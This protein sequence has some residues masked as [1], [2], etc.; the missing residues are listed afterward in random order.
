MEKLSP[1]LYEQIINSRLEKKLSKLDIHNEHVQKDSLKNFDSVALLSQ[2]LHSVLKKSLDFLQDSQTTSIQEQIACCNEIIALLATITQEECLTRCKI[3]DTGEILLAIGHLAAP[4]Q[5]SSISPRPITSLAQSCLFTG[6]S[7]EP[8]LIQEMKAEIESADRI[9]I[10]VS[11]IK[12]SG[13]RLLRDELS[14]FSQRGQLRVITTA[15]MGATDIP[16]VEF[17]AKLPNAEVRISYDTERTRLHAKAYYFKRNTGFSTAYIGSSN[18]S[19]PAIT[20]GLEWNVKLTE[21]DSHSLINKIEAS[22]ESYW[23]DPEFIRYEEQN[24]SIF[25]NAIQ[26]ERKG[27]HDEGTPVFF[28]IIPFYYQKEILDRLQAERT[29][30]HH[31]KNLIVAA[32]GTGKTVISAFDFRRFKD[33]VHSQARLLFIAHREEILKQSLYTFRT[34]LKDY[35]FGDLC[36]RG[37]IPGQKDHLFMSIQTFNSTEFWTHTSPDFYDFIIVDEFHHAAAASYQRLLSF[38]QPKVLLG[39]TATPERMDNLDVL[40]YFD[41]R[42]AAEIRL[43]EAI[44]RNLLAPFHYFGIT[45]TVNLDDL[46][47]SRGKYNQ[48]SLSKRYSGNIER[49]THIRNSLFQYVGDIDSVIGLGFC[50]SIEHAQYMAETFTQFG[51]PSTHL[52]SESSHEERNTVQT[53]LRNREIHFI[54]VVDLYNEGVD[55][56]QVN[57]ILFL[58]PTE[59]LTVFLQ[60]LGRGL[61]LSEGKE[62]LT[63][64][65]FVGRQNAHYRFDSKYRALIS[66][67]SSPIAL[68]IKKNTF[69]LPRGCYIHLEKV[70]QETVL[71]HIER[72]FSN[73]KALVQKIYEFQ[74]ESGKALGV[75]DFLTYYNLSPLD[76]YGKSSFRHLCAEAGLCEKPGEEDDEYIA[77]AARK[78]QFLDSITLIQFI[79]EFLAERDYSLVHDPKFNVFWYSIFSKSYKDLNYPDVV[80]G[81]KRL[82]EITWGVQEL[83]ELLSYLEEKTEVLER[84]LD[85]GYNNGLFL[86]CTYTRDQLFAALDHL[87]PEKSNVA[88][89][90]EGVLYIRE[91]NID[92]FLIT[93]NKSEKHFSPSTMYKDYAINE[94]LFH[95][96]SQ[97]TTSA[98]SPTGQRYIHHQKTGTKILLFVR[99]FDKINNVSQPYICLGTAN[100]VSHTGS[101]PM[102]IVWRLDNPIPPGFMKDAN[103]TI[104]G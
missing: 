64:L 104:A 53:R 83:D 82:F 29:I 20:S 32:T 25:I 24:K 2:Y 65:D 3:Q 37:Q 69:A 46:E 102:S 95:W 71:S 73:R 87:R 50:V 98:S 16:A 44:G 79:R 40:G 91:K 100:Y 10:L 47:W 103:K 85:I 88:G 14:R 57:T 49:A 35:N 12:W 33:T 19:N 58:R 13:I 67:G 27:T 22:F 89:K 55:I 93:L 68:Q 52:T 42:I 63:V 59:S 30:H 8:S 99:A 34:I 60:Q 74:E 21:K 39:L 15:Y 38:Y 31:Y 94:T 43:A 86:H 56:P 62:C 4:L 72:S 76:I 51:I 80:S 54:F 45:D 96:Q 70:A 101:K 78:I 28:D 23:N 61:R 97:S 9:D 90:R 17:L 1:G 5:Q 92:V 7:V 36:I 81:L 11:F 41:G 6:S 75:G 18:L 77:G 84:N 48:A 66:D 26:R